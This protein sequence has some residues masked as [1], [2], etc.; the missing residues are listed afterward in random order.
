MAL[1]QRRYSFYLAPTREIT[2]EG[3]SDRKVQG[4]VPLGHE[5]E[6]GRFAVAIGYIPPPPLPCVVLPPIGDSRDEPTDW[7]CQPL[8]VARP[9]SAWVQ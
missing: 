1:P 5:A 4:L 7:S 2:P 9:A 8:S 6:K 3:F